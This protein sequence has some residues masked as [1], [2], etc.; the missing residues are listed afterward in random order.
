MFKFHY[1]KWSYVFLWVYRHPTSAQPFIDRCMLP[2]PQAA[3]QASVPSRLM[4]TEGASAD[5]IL[6]F[7]RSAAGETVWREEPVWGPCR[8]LLQWDLG[9]CVW[10]SLGH[11]GRPSGMSTTGLW[12]GPGSPQEQSVWRWL[13]PHLPRRHEMLGHRDQPGAVPPPRPFCAQLWAPWGCRRHLFR[14]LISAGSLFFFPSNKP[15]RTHRG[16]RALLRQTCS[17]F[18]L[19]GLRSSCTLG[20]Q[21]PT[22]L[23]T[24]V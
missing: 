16:H 3:H 5:L 8:S 17:G 2:Q 24:L 4:I 15:G 12:G 13:W 7:C 20:L 23:V 6:G 21:Q 10:W 22:T 9:D 1:R 11:T 19:R 18:A 14:Y